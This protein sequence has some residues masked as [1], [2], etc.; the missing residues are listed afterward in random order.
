MYVFQ[1]QIVRTRCL[2]ELNRYKTIDGLA[3]KPPKELRESQ[4]RHDLRIAVGDRDDRIP[5]RI[6]EC[7]SE[8]PGA[9]PLT[10]TVFLGRIGNLS[11]GGCGLILDTVLTSKFTIGHPMFLSLLLPN[12]SEETI[13]LVEIRNITLMS[14]REKGTRLGVQFL[15]W[16]NRATLRRS[17]RP[18]EKL[19]AEMQRSAAKKRADARK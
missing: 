3:I 10:T 14:A 8:F 18:I 15:S 17:L 7:S 16:P 1:S 11:G 6:H 2:I 12:E 9:S 4:R 5:V 19:I 13:F